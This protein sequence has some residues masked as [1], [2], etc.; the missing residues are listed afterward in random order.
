MYD[1]NDKEKAI[2]NIQHR[3][4]ALGYYVDILN[5]RFDDTTKNSLMECL[6]IAVVN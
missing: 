3:L 5:G 1:L 4:K 6:H 2:R